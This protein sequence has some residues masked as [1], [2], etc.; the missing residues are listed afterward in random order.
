M[1]ARVEKMR[2]SLVALLFLVSLPSTAYASDFPAHAFEL[3]PSVAIVKTDCVCDGYS[4]TDGALGLGIHAGYRYRALSWLEVGATPTLSWISNGSQIRV[5]LIV[6]ARH[7]FAS[8]ASIWAGLGGG[9][10]RVDTT[11][12]ALPNTSPKAHLQGPFGTVFVG[13]SQPMTRAVSLF[14]EVAASLGG[15]TIAASRVYPGG[16]LDGSNGIWASLSLD[17][18][19]RLSL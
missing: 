7:S 17:A 16:Y 15:G 9:Y 12:D 3:G 6:D 1:T 4:L 14:V 13:A 2:T 8:G 18:G 10:F 11:L 19:V 5:P